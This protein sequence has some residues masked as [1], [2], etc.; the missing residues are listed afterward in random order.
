MVQFAIDSGAA[1]SVTPERMLAEHA[2]LPGDA[3]RK[4]TRYLAADGGRA[5]RLGE[6]E[7]GFV[8]KEQRRCQIKLQ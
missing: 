6:V 1:A 8:A 3:P 5:P 2:I 4:G 7:L